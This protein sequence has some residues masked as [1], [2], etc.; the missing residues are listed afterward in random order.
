MYHVFES[1]GVE[2]TPHTATYSLIGL[3]FV[4]ADTSIYSGE[5]HLVIFL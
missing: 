1:P 5:V 3:Q 2:R 4:N